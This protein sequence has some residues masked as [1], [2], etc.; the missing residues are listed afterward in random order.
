MII[1]EK[2][3]SY[4][5][6]DI[7]HPK[8]GKTLWS[9]R[10]CAVTGIVWYVDIMTDKNYFLISKRGSGAADFQGKWCLPCGFLEANETGEDGVLREIK[11]ETGVTVDFKPI[12]FSVE[13]DPQYCNNGNVTLR[14]ICPMHE[15]VK[16]KYE[17]INGEENEVA[18]LR[19]ISEDEIGLYDFCFNHEDILYLFLFQYLNIHKYLPKIY[20]RL[21]DVNG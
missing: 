5:I 8:Y 10:Y 1:M 2:N 7:N 19:W 9:G 11:E 12:F 20:H 21:K 6:K 18:D 16:P 15:M 17:N 14:Y 4:T 3:W 13:T